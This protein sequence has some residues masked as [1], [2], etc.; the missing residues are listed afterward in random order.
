MD[1]IYKHPM[2]LSTKVPDSLW[3]QNSLNFHALES[4][5]SL[6]CS[7]TLWTLWEPKW[8]R[9]CVLNLGLQII[10]LSLCVNKRCVHKKWCWAIS[11]RRLPFCRAI[12]RLNLRAILIYLDP[13]GRDSTKAS[14]EKTFS[15]CFY[16]VYELDLRTRSTVDLYDHLAR[17]KRWNIQWVPIIGK[18]SLIRCAR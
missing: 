8:H 4:K 18:V 15:L 5:V 14:T 9:K 12:F 11:A 13:L 2:A 3:W 6:W 10:A 16:L 7:R 1:V 17:W